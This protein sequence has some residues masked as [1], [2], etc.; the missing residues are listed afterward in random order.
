MYENVSSNVYI[1]FMMYETIQRKKDILI[2]RE[3]YTNL[4]QDHA[5]KIVIVQKPKLL[6]RS[7][8]SFPSTVTNFISYC[9]HNINHKWDIACL[10]A[11]GNLTRIFRETCFVF[12][13]LG[14]NVSKKSGPRNVG[15][16]QRFFW[17]SGSSFH[18]NFVGAV[19]NH[20]VPQVEENILHS[21]YWSLA[22]KYNFYFV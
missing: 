8:A 1:H 20:A 2:G 4:R 19:Q 10:T 6:P 3:I 12:F 11:F 18:L 15:V 13:D 22:G 5:K 21:L 9:I 17:A 16:G 7:C 14:S